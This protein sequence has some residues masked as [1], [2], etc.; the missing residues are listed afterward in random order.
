MQSFKM[1]VLTDHSNHSSENS[2]YALARAM[3]RHPQ[4]LRIDVASRGVNRNKYFFKNLAVN[5][6]VAHKVDEH[7]QYLPN[8]LAFQQASKL[9]SVSDYDVVWLRMPPPLSLNFVEFLTATFPNQLF[10]NNPLG[11]YK[12]GSK[13][14][15]LNFPDLCPPMKMCRSIADILDLKQQFPIVL[16]PLREYGGKGIVRIDGDQVWAGKKNLSF[17]DFI[18]TLEPD[19]IEYLGVQ[20]LK[21]VTEGDKRII[22]V[23]GKIMGASLRLPAK[24]SWLC[25]VSMG[26]HAIH[27]EVTEEEI[28]I[29]EQVNPILQS[30]GIVMYGLDTLMGNYGKRVLSEINTTSIGGLPQMADFMG[31]PLVEEATTIIGEYIRQQLVEFV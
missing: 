5:N 22:V 8:G 12:T 20:F 28:Q 31:K 21:N 30:M 17:A 4:C 27:T 7:F 23:R 19:N 10:I 18:R 13:E 2:L 14:F 15:L 16:K 6:V 29:V 24:D 9:V 1:L 11:I 3:H 26:G 25:N